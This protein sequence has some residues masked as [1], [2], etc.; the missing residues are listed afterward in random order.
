MLMVDV[1]KIP[2]IV[3]AKLIK[4]ISYFKDGVEVVVKAGTEIKVDIDS[5]IALIGRD[6]ADIFTD[7]FQVLYQN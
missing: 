6:H 7:E 1:S 3:S 4:E 5:Q 2:L